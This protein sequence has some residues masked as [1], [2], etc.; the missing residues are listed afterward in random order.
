MQYLLISGSGYTCNLRSFGLNETVESTFLMTDHNPDICCS[1][2]APRVPGAFARIAL[3]AIALC[4]GTAQAANINGRVF[5]D[6]NYGGGAGRTYAAAAGVGI[7]GVRIELYN[8]AGNFVATDTT[9]GGG[10]NVGRYAFNG[11]PAGTYTVRVA[12]LTVASTRTGACAAGTCIPVQTFR[13]NAASGAAVPVTNFVGGQVPGLSD[14]G[15]GNTTLA[16]LT[17]ATTTAQSISTVVLAGPGTTVADVDFGFNFDTIVNVNNAGQGSLRQFIINS[18]AKTGEGSLAQVGQT[19]GRETSIFM[20]ANGI[21]NPGHNTG[22]A[23]LL[24]VGG[25]N[26]GAA[27]ITLASALP[28]ITGS[29][30]SLDGR[31]QTAN[32]RATAGGG[33]TNPGLVG[34]GGTVGTSAIALAQFDRPEVVI[35]AVATRVA[36][37]GSNVFIRGIAVENGGILVSGASSEVRDCLVGIRAD[38]T[39][40]T[41]YGATYGITIGAGANILISHNYVKVNNSGIRGDSTGANAILEYNEVDSLT[42]TPGGGHTAT[43]D[44]VLIIGSAS[45]TT[46]RFNLLKNQ[47]GGGLEFGFGGGTITGTVTENTVTSNGFTSAGVPSTEG[48]GVAFYFL[49]GGSSMTFSNN[50]VSNNAGPGVVV[51]RATNIVITRNSIFGNGTTTGLG[52]D[53]DI[54]VGTDPNTYMPPDGVTLNDN[55]DIDTGPNNL[56]NY[57]VVQTATVTDT[58]LTVTGWARPGSLI[59]FFVAAPDGTGFGEGETYKFSATEG[60]SDADATSSTYGPAAIN[61]ILQGT[62]TTNRFSFTIPTPAGVAA[63]TVLTATAQL[64]GQTSEF[65]GNVTVIRYP[66]Y[67][68]TKTSSV[69]SDPVNCATPGSPASCVPL[70]SQKRIPGSIVEYQLLVSNAGGATDIDTVIITDIVPTTGAELFVGDLGAPGSGPVA[71]VD[72]A[73]A[74]GLSYNFITLGNAGDDVAFSSDAGP[75]YTYG[76]TPTPG[77]N[78]CDPAVTALRINPKGVFVADAGTPDPSFT[79]RF[80]VCIP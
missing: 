48:M 21:A 57:P 65:S 60:I 19:A 20:I 67:T 6:I 29:N 11:I 61:G 73:S 32:V 58:N 35:N 46:I 15:N 75:A 69:L 74:S 63:G 18:N 10:P 78:G 7:N 33:E 28:T 12:N 77:V 62:D 42:G 51:M 9:A 13:T 45:N 76:Y 27:R 54:R 34:T 26:G 44:G 56:L 2:S 64:G 40:G 59:E 17:T 47:R 30:T 36:A 68:V 3:L 50:I 80:W 71:F 72:G 16:A 52:I 41:T 31:T 43:F 66:I 23:N 4:C 25:A 5:E 1:S 37:S 22:Y 70:G 53:N 49:S 55:G 38:G 8:A 79:L 14:A 24:T 39:V